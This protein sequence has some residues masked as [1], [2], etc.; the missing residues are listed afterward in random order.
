VRDARSEFTTAPRPAVDPA[1]GSHPAAGRRRTGELVDG[2]DNDC[3]GL[4]LEEEIDHDGDGYVHGEI[5]AG[6]WDGSGLVVGGGD[7]EDSQESIYPG[8]PEVCDYL[9]NDC[10]EEI[11]ETCSTW[12]RDQDEDGYGTYEDVVWAETPPPGYVDNSDDCDDYA[13][14]IH[15]GAV[16]LCN[17]YDDDCAGGIDDGC[18]YRWFADTDGDGYGDPASYVDALEAPPGYVGDPSDCDDAEPSVHPDGCETCDGLDN[19]CDGETDESC[20]GPW[21]LDADLDGFGNPDVS[22]CAPSPPYGYAEN[23]ED[24]DDEDGSVYPGAEEVCDG[25]D[26]DCD[27]EADEGAML[28]WYLD[29]DHDGYGIADVS[30]LSCEWVEGYAG[31][32]GDCD[33]ADPLV[34]PGQ[35]E[36]CNGGDD[37]CDGQAD[38]PPVVDGSF[39]LYRDA[40]LDSWGGE[41]W[42]FCEEPLPIP[43]GFCTRGGDCDEADPDVNPD[44]VEVCDG[45]DNDCDGQVDEGLLVDWYLDLD[46]DGYG[47]ADLDPQFIQ[48]L[49]PG[50][51]PEFPEFFVLDHTD[52]DDTDDDVNPG[53]VEVCDAIDNDCDGVI[54]EGLATYWYPDYDQDGYGSTE[55]AGDVQLVCNGL[56][57]ENPDFFVLNTDDCDDARADV[58]PGATDV[59]DFADN[60][61]DGVVDEDC[62]GLSILS[63]R[64]VGNDQGRH[65]RVRWSRHVLESP[66]GTPSIT[67]YSLY[68]RID[69][70]KSCGDGEPAAL[71]NAPPGEWDWVATLP[72]TG[73]ETYSLVSTTLCDSTDAGI[74]WSVFFVRAHTADTFT[75][76]DAPPDSGYSR[77]NLFPSAPQGLAAAYASGGVALTWQASSIDDLRQYRI[78]R[79]AGEVAAD[80][81]H[82]LDATTQPQWTDPA[83]DAWG[84][85]YLVT[86]VDLAGNESPPA[87]PQSVTGMSGGLPTPATWALL[88]PAP[89]PFNPTTTLT[90]EVP[91]GGGAVLLRVYDLAGHVVRTLAEGHRD[92]GRHELVWDGRDAGGRPAP[93]GVYLFRLTAGGSSMSRTA[94]MTK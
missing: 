39:A 85:V 81:A 19:D 36:L 45:L 67:W 7:C 52:C 73:Q 5:D 63:I 79:G 89:N 30:V 41:L 74:C 68:R 22:L 17:G 31:I 62:T 49:C 64:D 87:S 27:G 15:P 51:P 50:V 93:S 77:D 2:L 33:D 38:E 72:A 47:A 18:L 29:Q 20:G 80:P 35:E 83:H 4:L 48:H 8:A 54:D 59:C 78:Y 84:Y 53:A 37:D 13:D 86:T 24:C 69:A 32:A 88:P 90:Y 56:P 14:W 34:N 70:W 75:F 58:H 82:L 92:A 40:D 9:D 66:G 26:N 25:R 46:Q 55:P 3:D 1:A 44:G 91:A 60:D 10:D 42:Q 11:D 16:E 6:G 94:V 23:P 57:P 28:T 12:F 43:P 61:C 21:W 76:F 65:V 71:P